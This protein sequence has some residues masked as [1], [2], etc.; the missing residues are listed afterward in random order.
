MALWSLS[1]MCGNHLAQT[2]HFPKLLVRIRSKLAGETLTSVATAVHE[3]LHIH[4]RTDFTCSMWRSSVVDVGAPLQE[5]SS[6]SSQP[7]LAF[8]NQNTV[9]CEG[10][11]VPKPSF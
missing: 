4:S 5:T 11:C 8:N 6:V 3:M 9:S 2:F 1:S 10:A 7:F